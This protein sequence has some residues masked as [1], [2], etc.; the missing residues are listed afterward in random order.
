VR[1]RLGLVLIVV[2][3][4]GRAPKVAQGDPRDQKRPWSFLSKVE[5]EVGGLV[6]FAVAAQRA[7]PRERPG[8]KND[9]GRFRL[10]LR[11]RLGL[12]LLLLLPPEEHPK[13]PREIPGANNDLGRGL[14]LGM[15]MAVFV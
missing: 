13:R 7:W 10:W 14:R 12:G 4:A 15:T 3:A 1:L 5:V 11:L 8:T 6:I 2:A 9:H